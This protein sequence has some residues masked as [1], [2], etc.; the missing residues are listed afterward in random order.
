MLA[1]DQEQVVDRHLVARF[2]RLARRERRAVRAH[3]LQPL[4]VAA[5]RLDAP[6]LGRAGH[7]GPEVVAVVG[8]QSTAHQD[9]RV[10]GGRERGRV[11]GL[12]LEVA[13]SRAGTIDPDR[14]RLLV[15]LT[16]HQEQV[17]AGLEAQAGERDPFGAV[18]A[19]EA[20]PL[21][22]H[23]TQLPI[24]PGAPQQADIEQLL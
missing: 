18:A 7:R 13:W 24:L 2:A 10:Q 17:A 15:R 4:E 22:V 6:Q 19:L 16:V 23:Q 20:R 21:V 9:R 5:V 1:G 11:V 12:R 3:Q 14:V 8:R